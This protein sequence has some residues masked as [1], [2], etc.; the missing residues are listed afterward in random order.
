MLPLITAILS[1]P[2]ALGFLGLLLFAPTAT[3]AWIV[4]EM[5]K[6]DRERQ[7]QIDDLKKVLDTRTQEVKDET[8]EIKKMIEISD[9][10]NKTFLDLMVSIFK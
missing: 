4:W 8:L 1:N 5:F 10:R 3:M 9:E 2:T 7:S 6:R